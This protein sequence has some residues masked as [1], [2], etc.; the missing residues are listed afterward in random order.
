MVQH[1]V[2]PIRALAVRASDPLGS[3]TGGGA[4]LA[5]ISSVERRNPQISIDEQFSKYSTFSQNVG[6]VRL[7]KFMGGGGLFQV[8]VQDSPH[9]AS[10]AFRFESIFGRAGKCPIACSPV[11]TFQHS[12][13]PLPIIRKRRGSRGGI[14]AGAHVTLFLAGIIWQHTEPL[15]VPLARSCANSE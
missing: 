15:D 7:C 8:P 4:N 5:D 12:T 10:H 11:G 14:S 1:I 3:S 13:R 6:I 2:R 9:P